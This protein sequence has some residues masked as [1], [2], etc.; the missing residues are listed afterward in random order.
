MRRWAKAACIAVAA[1]VLATGCAGRAIQIGFGDP[2]PEIPLA[3]PGEARY[4]A[5]LAEGT[6]TWYAAWYDLEQTER[7]AELFEQTYPGI[8]VQVLRQS[9]G[10]VYQRFL[11]E[12]DARQFTADVLSLGDQSLAF[13]L[14]DRGDLARFTPEGVDHLLP[15]YRD[16]DP[17]GYL[18]VAGAAH[19]VITYN[20]NLVPENEVPRTWSGLLDPRWSGQIAAS[21]PA[22][23]GY[24]SAWATAM[25]DRYGEH[26]LERLAQQNV[27]VGQSIADTLPRVAGGERQ[28]GI[29]G[30][31]SAATQMRE[32]SPIRLVYPEDGA[33]LIRS[34]LAIP[35]NAPHPNAARLFA[36]FIYG[37]VYNRDFVEAQQFA[38]F[39]DLS[40]PPPYVPEGMTEI[41]LP[42]QKLTDELLPVIDLWRRDFGA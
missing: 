34:V 30:S 38:P 11:Q 15:Q 1:S 23:N 10:R 19:V 4:Q 22:A 29:S 24:A 32:G 16:L 35:V 13:D 17:E 37:E 39:T 36:D 20:P 18:H 26:Y 3:E 31:S 40:A 8:D 7:A 9:S 25:V 5:A 12:S 33:V 21:H 2:P 41:S 42:Q 14:R 28:V 6:L 27:L